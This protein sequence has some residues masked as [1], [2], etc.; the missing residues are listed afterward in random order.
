[1]LDYSL[2]YKTTDD[3]RNNGPSQDLTSSIKNA[4]SLKKAL[5]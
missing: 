3:K 4:T 5:K 2:V 1:M